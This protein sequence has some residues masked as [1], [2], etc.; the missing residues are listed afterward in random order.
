MLKLANKKSNSKNKNLNKLS[1]RYSKKKVFLWHFNKWLARLQKKLTNNR[2][3]HLLSIKY[4][5]KIKVS[6]NID[7]LAYLDEKLTNNRYIH[8]L[9]TKYFDKIRV[10]IDTNYIHLDN[11]LMTTIWQKSKNVITTMTFWCF[12]I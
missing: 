10:V 12:Y 2:Y 3:M 1:S 7:W 6:V 5:D 11:N 8:L 9:L 4:S